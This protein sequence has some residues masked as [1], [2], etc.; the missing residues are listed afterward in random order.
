MLS[1][2]QFEWTVQVNKQVMYQ[3]AS[4]FG[5]CGGVLISPNHVLTAAHCVEHAAKVVNEENVVISFDNIKPFWLQTVM[6]YFTYFKVNKNIHQ[7]R[8]SKIYFPSGYVAGQLDYQ[9]DIAIIRLSNTVDFVNP[10]ALPNMMNTDQHMELCQQDFI[11]SGYGQGYH[12]DEIKLTDYGICLLNYG[13]YQDV[14]HG[15]Y[16]EVIPSK[17]EMYCTDHK[18]NRVSNHLYLQH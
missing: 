16:V 13:K 3:N 18:L 10:I 2:D 9:T 11:F 5:V 17:R 4:H 7:T 14:N 6:P 12:V 8:A 15:W 1:N